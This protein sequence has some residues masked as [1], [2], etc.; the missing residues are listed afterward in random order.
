MKYLIFFAFISSLFGC[1]TT[2]SD[3]TFSKAHITATE[4]GTNKIL[5]D[6]II[7]DCF[8]ASKPDGYGLIEI[9]GAKTADAFKVTYYEAEGDMLNVKVGS[10]L[11]EWRRN[12]GQDIFISG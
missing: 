5:D 1:S 12:K 11:T 9:K 7:D 8:T 4:V 2:S 6:K 10:K 3:C